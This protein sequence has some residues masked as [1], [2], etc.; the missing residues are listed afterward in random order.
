MEEMVKEV[1]DYL[2][3]RVTLIFIFMLLLVEYCIVHTVSLVALLIFILD[4]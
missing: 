4:S 3:N 2:S 1:E